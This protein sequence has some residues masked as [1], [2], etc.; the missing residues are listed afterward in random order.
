MRS[1]LFDGASRLDDTGVGGDPRSGALPAAEPVDAI[2]RL[3]RTGAE[4][5]KL[6]VS[7]HGIEHAIAPVTARRRPR[8]ILMT[9]NYAP[10][11][12]GP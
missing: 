2:E 3:S 8:A 1:P 10:G 7:C 6:A 4:P 12:A 11:A 9:N 5:S